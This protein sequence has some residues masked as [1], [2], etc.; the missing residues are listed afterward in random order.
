[1]KLGYAQTIITPSKEDFR[2]PLNPLNPKDHYEETMSISK[3]M[4]PK[5][6]EAVDDL[7]RIHLSNEKWESFTENTK[8][9]SL[10]SK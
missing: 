7:L 9:L 5:L 2:Y 3:E 4:G 8:I 10:R 6:M 1:M